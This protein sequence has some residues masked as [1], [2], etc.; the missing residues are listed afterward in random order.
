[1]P[2]GVYPHTKTQG[3]QKGHKLFGSRPFQKGISNVKHGLWYHP[4]YRTWQ[5]MMQRC[6]N[7]KIWEY[8]D[9]GAKGVTVWEPWHDLS[10]FVF[11]IPALLGDR[12]ER[13]TLDRVNPHEGYYEWNVRWG[14]WKTQGRNKRNRIPDFLS[15]C[16][17]H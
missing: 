1:M 2:K 10:I 5:R 11:A 12:P 15:Q 8:K 9:Y 7:P 13:Y 6:Y 3:F 17:E 16:G 4:L 14:D